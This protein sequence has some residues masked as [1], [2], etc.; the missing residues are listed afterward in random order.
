MKILHQCVM[1][2]TQLSGRLSVMRARN[3]LIPPTRC[4]GLAGY[5]VGSLKEGCSIILQTRVSDLCMNHTS[6]RPNAYN[7]ISEWVLALLKSLLNLL[8]WCPWQ[9][10]HSLLPLSSHFMNSKLDWWPVNILGLVLAAEKIHWI[11]KRASIACQKILTPPLKNW[12]T[13]ALWPK[14][15]S[16]GEPMWVLR[17]EN[18]HTSGCS[19]IKFPYSTLIREA[20]WHLAWNLDPRNQLKIG[21]FHWP[22][23]KSPTNESLTLNIVLRFPSSVLQ[24]RQS[25]RCSVLSVIIFTPWSWCSMIQGIIHVRCPQIISLTWELC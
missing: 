19:F 15:G 22:G 6:I 11:K 1:F 7:F 3:T 24:S 10:S 17:F 12:I 25:Y 18:Y 21:L 23:I 16:A 13:A 4:G 20:F 14:G 5:T 8:N 9:K 2:Q